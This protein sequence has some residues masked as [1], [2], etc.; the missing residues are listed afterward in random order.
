MPAVCPRAALRQ[1]P[2]IHLGLETVLPNGEV[3]RLRGLRKDNTGYDLKQLFIGAEGTL[4]I[5]TAAVLKLF[6]QPSGGRHGLVGH[7]IA[8]RRGTVARRTAKR[9]RYLADGLRTGLGACSTSSSSTSRARQPLP[10]TSPW[11][12]LVELSAPDGESELNAG[13]ER[14]RN[15]VRARHGE[16]RG[17]R[18][19]YRADAQAVGAAREHQRGGKEGRISI[20]HDISLPISRLSRVP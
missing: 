1:Y 9:F 7:R 18:P 2:R 17:D 14:F 6:P 4:G 20:K 16:R 5:I 19:E 15:G 3:G 8:E 10:V 11:Y 12:L 13:L